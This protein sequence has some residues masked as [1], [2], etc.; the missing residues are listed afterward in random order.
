MQPGRRKD[1]RNDYAFKILPVF[2][3]ILTSPI[4]AQIILSLLKQ[5]P[6]DYKVP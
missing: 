5:L 1:K 6:K 2:C 3:F 4:H